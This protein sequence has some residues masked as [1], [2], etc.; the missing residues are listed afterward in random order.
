MRRVSALGCMNCYFTY[1]R[2]MPIKV[3]S[4]EPSLCGSSGGVAAP[5]A[6]LAGVDAAA[7]VDDEVEAIWKPG[8]AMRKP[9]C[10]FPLV[11]AAQYT[12]EGSAW[13]AAAWRLKPRKPRP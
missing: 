1:L 4:L 7:G 12:S 3:R 11:R 2:R 8:L 5:E 10:F 13:Q 6:R 9:R